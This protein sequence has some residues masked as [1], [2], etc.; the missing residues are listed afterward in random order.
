[1]RFLFGTLSALG[2]LAALAVH[3]FALSGIAVQD[4]WPTVWALHIGVFVVFIPA[5]FYLRKHSDENDP[6][7]LFRGLPTWAGLAL[8]ALFVY[9]FLNF[10][11]SLSKTAGATPELRDGRYVLH[12]KGSVVREITKEEYTAG[13]AAQ[14]RLFSGHWLLFYS[15]PVGV[16]LLLR[17]PSEA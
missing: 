2:F 13:R 11:V 5:A 3:A 9:A 14:A 15:I 6:V 12:N 7:A 1:M 10:F 4:I 8:V 16:F 17:H